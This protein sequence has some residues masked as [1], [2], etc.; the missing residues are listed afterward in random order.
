MS[1]LTNGFHSVSIAKKLRKRGNQY[2]LRWMDPVTC[3]R[4]STVVGYDRTRADLERKKLENLLNG[5]ML[6]IP[7]GVSGFVYGSASVT[8][9]EFWKRFTEVAGASLKPRTIKSYREC[10]KVF[11]NV[12][13]DKKH[14]QDIKPYDVE[15]FI[16][17]RLKKVSGST[18]NKD[19][20][21]L[22]A[23]FNRAVKWGLLAG[24]PFT[25]RKRLKVQPREVRV[26][27]PAEEARILNAIDRM[28][29]YKITDILRLKKKAIFYLARQ[30]GLRNG[31]IRHL[32]WMDVDSTGKVTASCRDD[33]STKNGKNRTVY[34]DEQALAVLRDLRLRVEGMPTD[35]PFYYRSSSILAHIF[36]KVTKAANVDCGLHDLRRTCA[37]RMAENS[38]PPQVLMDYM[39]HSSLQVT[40]T[41][42]TK[43]GEIS[44][45]R[46]MRAGLAGGND[47]ANKQPQTAISDHA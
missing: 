33:W 21:E 41:F 9:D 3:K 6:N 43:I 28:P 44:L 38:V 15:L 37:T 26:I 17:L 46:A 1:S 4:M 34:V 13:P 8:F 30:G 18:V 45:E 25:G 23:L 24:N 32:R 12:L 2:N 40:M 42:Y 36:A 39:G 27:T 10:L 47:Y 5:N 19:I 11:R 7:Q 16:G 35:T 14:L 29:H 22:K 31:E 20:I